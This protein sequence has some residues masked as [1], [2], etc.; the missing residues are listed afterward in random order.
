MASTTLAAALLVIGLV[1]GAGIGY[2]A[3]SATTSSKTVTSTVVSTVTG[4]GGGGGSATTVTQTVTGTGGGGGGGGN[5]TYTIGIVFPLTSSLAAFGKSFVN[6]VNL[7][8]QQ[9]NANLSASG[10]PIRFKTVVADDQGTPAGALQAVQTLHTTDGVNVIIGPLTTAEVLGVRDYADTNHIL[11][12]PP[13]SSGTAAAIPNDYILRPGQPGDAFEGSALAQT[14]NHFGMK[15]VVYIYSSDTSEAGTFNLT[16]SLL[17]ADGVK[18]TGIE[19]QPLQS[20]YS[21]AVS[22]AD[23]D[24]GNA[25]SG[26]GTTANTAVVLGEHGT[27]AENILSHAST[28]QNLGKVRWF[29]IEALNDQLLLNDSTVGPFMNK[30]NLTI[31]TLYTPG[32]PQ[33]QAFLSNY[34]A[35][36]GAPPEPFTNYAYDVAWIALLSIAAAGTTNG[37]ALLSIVPVVA[38]HYFGSSGTPTYLDKNG[39]QSIGF[40]A[41]DLCVKN[42]TQFQFN[43]IGLYD[44]SSNTVSFSG[45]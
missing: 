24:V 6:G 15:N 31:T 26:G 29:G 27:D 17:Q 10:S 37:Q 45:P 30:V 20:D 42:A 2:A 32:S 1:V 35:V 25:L 23:L 7:A 19:V 22:T 11:L 28:S 14:I 36:Y 40:F 41:I 12:L 44:G 39:D 4:T 9:F 34:Q 13:A 8:V 16:Q 43:Q 18:V 3:V 5:Q 21:S 33:G 38:N